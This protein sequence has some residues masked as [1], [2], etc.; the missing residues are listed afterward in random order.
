MIQ[1]TCYS[2]SASPTHCRP[3]A[4]NLRASTYN[5]LRNCCL[6]PVLLLGLW[7]ANI[8]RSAS[9]DTLP[10]AVC[11]ISCGWVDNNTL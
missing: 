7:S 2:A 6:L 8:F 1:A 3:A 10:V 5:L 9:F 11:G 4:Q